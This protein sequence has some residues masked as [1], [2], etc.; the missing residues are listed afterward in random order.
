[1]DN[2]Y[3]YSGPV[4]EFGRCITAKWEAVTYA[5]SE[6]K[7]RSNLEYRFKRENKRTPNSKISLPG[8]IIVTQE[9]H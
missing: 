4:T 2:R 8:K 3:S 9:E 5:P 1:M 6:I 7:A